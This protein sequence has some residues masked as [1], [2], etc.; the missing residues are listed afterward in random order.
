VVKSRKERKNDIREPNNEIS[1]INQ[2]QIQTPR[3]NT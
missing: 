1:G 3:I 2:Y